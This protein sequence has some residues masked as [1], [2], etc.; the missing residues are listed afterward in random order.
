MRRAQRGTNDRKRL[1][2]GAHL[3]VVVVVHAAEDLHLGF[4]ETC[5]P[6]LRRRDFHSGKIKH[7]II[8]I[9]T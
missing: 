4:N 8:L 7:L 2:H 9:T 1:D 3:L 5:P 6:A